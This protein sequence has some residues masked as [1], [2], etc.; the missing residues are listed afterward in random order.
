MEAKAQ[1]T[2][3]KRRYFE[4]GN[5]QLRNCRRR[6]KTKFCIR[7]D[8]TKVNSNPIFF[9]VTCLC[10]I[11]II[12]NSNSFVRLQITTMALIILSIS[13]SAQL[14]AAQTLPSFEC[15][16]S[17][18]KLQ[19]IKDINTPALNEEIEYDSTMP[20]C[21][22]ARQNLISRVRTEIRSRINEVEILP[23]YSNCI[24]EKLTGSESFVHSV[25]KAAIFEHFDENNNSLNRTIASILKEINNSIQICRQE[26]EVGNEFD[27]I[28]NATF[29]GTRNLTKHEEYCIKKYLIKNNLIDIYTYDIDPNPHNINVTG[30]NCEEMIRKSNEE[31]Y[32]QLSTIYFQK[33]NLS[34]DEKVECAVD[35]FR[36]ADY[37][38]LVMKITALSTLNITS[39][40]KIIER[41]S[42][43]QIFSNITSKIATC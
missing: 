22:T 2:R 16:V 42:F 1:A 20:E 34:N 43:I 17:Y 25:I 5:S 27:V 15:L 32:D 39:E 41:E 40:Q 13:T 9:C 18:A 10:S 24:Y 4:M 19:G 23:R 28:F 3:Y 37:F 6:I 8:F 12:S 29:D 14:T 31:V 38:D 11:D 33:P 21:T 30:L 26:D 35:K 36:E 7:D